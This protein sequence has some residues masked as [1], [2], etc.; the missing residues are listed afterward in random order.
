LQNP[1]IS[2]RKRTDMAGYVLQSANHMRRMIEDLLDVART[3]L[4]GS[5]PVDLS[6]ANAAEICNRV[7]AEMRA[8]HPDRQFHLKATGDLQGMWDTARVEQ[9]LSNLMSNAAQHGD[10]TKPISVVAEADRDNVMLSV[11]NEGE[12]IPEQMLIRIFEP[13]VRGERAQDGSRS[14]GN[15]G[16]GLYIA[17]TVARAHHGSINVQSSRAAGTTLK[18]TLP[19]TPGNDGES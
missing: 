3:K 5:L 9:L 16:L 6:S 1:D 13:L 4:G 8:L 19:R 18:V 7:I 12:P 17:C 14:A 11:H 2:E 15:M 10:S